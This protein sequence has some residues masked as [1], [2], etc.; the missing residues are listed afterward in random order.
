MQNN[1]NNKKAL[2]GYSYTSSASGYSSQFNQDKSHNLNK[3][4]NYLTDNKFYERNNNINSNYGNTNHYNIEN[5]NKKSDSTATE[6]KYTWGFQVLP[7]LYSLYQKVR[8]Q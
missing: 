6:N 5:Y 4:K 8:E 7:T 1:N 3:N 2:F